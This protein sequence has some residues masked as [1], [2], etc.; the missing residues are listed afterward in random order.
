LLLKLLY[1]RR[2]KFYYVAHIIFTIH[3]YVFVYIQLLFINLISKIADYTKSGLMY[4]ITI[5]LS[6]A[7][8]YYMYKAMRNFY[9]QSRWK[10]MLKLIILS[11]F[12]IF[13]FT[14]FLIFL[15]GFSFYKT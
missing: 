11:F 6:F 5:V 12:L 10:T 15:I 9:E 4:D 14:F 3:F 8:F 7:F 2:K 1:I 13:L